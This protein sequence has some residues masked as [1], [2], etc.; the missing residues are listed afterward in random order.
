MT[1]VPLTV[2]P[3]RVAEVRVRPGDRLYQFSAFNAGLQAAIPPRA[4]VTHARIRSVVCALF[5]MWTGS[6][7]SFSWGKDGFEAEAWDDRGRRLTVRQ[8][9]YLG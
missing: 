2:L 8:I 7:P 6:A 9:N 5:R 1:S 3:Q 4:V